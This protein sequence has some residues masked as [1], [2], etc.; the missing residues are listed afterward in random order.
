MAE[1]RQ[2]FEIIAAMAAERAGRSDTEIL[3]E[4]EAQPPLVDEED[5]AWDRPE[6]WSEAHRYL[7][8]ADVAAQRRLR[9]ALR[10][11]LDKAC[12]GDP[13]EIMRGLRHSLEAIVNPDWSAL[14]DVCLEAAAHSPRL[15]TRYWAL[16][17]LS[18]L[19]DPRARPLFEEIM[20]KGPAELRDPAEIGLERLASRE[21]A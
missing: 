5:A 2:P 7:A 9:A 10:P 20:R 16:E 21:G 18:I 14:A 4:L 13:G 1:E 11:L 8:L 19:D 17:E 12:L 6:Y 15:G 3:A